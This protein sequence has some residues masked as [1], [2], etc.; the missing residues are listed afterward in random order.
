MAPS[1]A[2]GDT[3]GTSGMRQLGLKQAGSGRALDDACRCHACA[4]IQCGVRHA[5]S[6]LL[7]AELAAEQRTEAGV[8]SEAAQLVT[9]KRLLMPLLSDAIKECATRSD[10]RYRAASCFGFK[11]SNTECANVVQQA[12]RQS[13]VARRPCSLGG[14]KGLSGWS[15][16]GSCCS[17]RRG[18]AE[19]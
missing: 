17:D 12:V 1:A 16:C 19:V 18:A 7:A 15:K 4:G 9:A 3:Q 11:V 2:T 13:R 10:L 5:P 14:A 6:R 8:R